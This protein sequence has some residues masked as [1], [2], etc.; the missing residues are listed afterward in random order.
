ME[1]WLARLQISYLLARPEVHRCRPGGCSSLPEMAGNGIKQTIIS[2]KFSER[3]SD[4]E[5]G[6]SVPRQK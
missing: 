6:L 5:G 3:Q 1:A 4:V 2:V